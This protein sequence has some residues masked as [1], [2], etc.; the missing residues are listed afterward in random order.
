[1]ILNILSIVLGLCFFL[2]PLWAYRQGLKDGLSIKQDK[3]MEPLPKLTT[4]FKK[5]QVK[6]EN[7]KLSEGLQNIMSYDGTRQKEEDDK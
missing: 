1:M 2:V 6:V 3:P 4:P 5:A 7:D